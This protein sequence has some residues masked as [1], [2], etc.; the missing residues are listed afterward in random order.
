M[1]AAQSKKRRKERKKRRRQLSNSTAEFDIPRSASVDVIRSL[2]VSTSSCLHCH[3]LAGHRA[4][5]ASLG[6]ETC[7]RTFLDSVGRETPR[8]TFCDSFSGCPHSPQHRCVRDHGHDVSDLSDG[9]ESCPSCLTSR[10]CLAVSSPS[11]LGVMKDS[12]ASLNKPAPE[13]SLRV[14]GSRSSEFLGIQETF[15]RKERSEERLLSRAENSH[16][17]AA[18]SSRPF[19]SMQQVAS[20]VKPVGDTDRPAKPTRT[21]ERCNQLQDSATF[22]STLST[23]EVPEAQRVS[24]SGSDPGGESVSDTCQTTTC[25]SKSDGK[26]PIKVLEDEPSIL[27]RWEKQK[28]MAQQL[29]I[30]RKHIQAHES[31]STVPPPAPLFTDNEASCHGVE[32]GASEHMSSEEPQPRTLPHDSSSRGSEGNSKS[33]RKTSRRKF[34]KMSNYKYLDSHPVLSKLQNEQNNRLESMERRMKEIRISAMREA[35]RRKF[36]EI[37][38][39]K[40]DNSETERMIQEARETLERLKEE[41]KVKGHNQQ[42]QILHQKPTVVDSALQPRVPLSNIENCNV[43]ED[44]GEIVPVHV[45]HLQGNKAKSTA[46]SQTEAKSQGRCSRKEE[47]VKKPDWVNDTWPNI[48]LGHPLTWIWL[49]FLIFPLILRLILSFIVTSPSNNNRSNS[50]RRN[51][52][53]RGS[54]VDTSQI[55]K[56]SK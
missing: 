20:W 5:S 18:H 39:A 45:L 48:N 23:L 17:L 15:M 10:N 54:C 16:L 50:N 52:N 1:G 43:E 56:P 47:A 2:N 38:P 24:G 40:E 21:S 51:S 27:A 12:S 42:Q 29:R 37:F 55:N 33:P 36:A 19:Q 30:L 7:H 34:T 22:S 46:E 6:R 49:P 41:R 3:S 13:S 4:L 31:S 14:M 44:S 8:R 28:Y 11:Y 26:L 35:E 9:Y 25:S 53:G 32:S